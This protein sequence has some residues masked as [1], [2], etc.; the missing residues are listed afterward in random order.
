GSTTVEQSHFAITL[1]IS[2]VALCSLSTLSK[3]DPISSIRCYHRPTP[4]THKHSYITTI[5]LQYS[6]T[7]T[8][9]HTHTHTNTHTHAHTHMH[10]HAQLRLSDR[11]RMLFGT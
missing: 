4:T 2:C 5:S 11:T 9:T 6:H 7:H 10:T 1:R 3:L 8:P